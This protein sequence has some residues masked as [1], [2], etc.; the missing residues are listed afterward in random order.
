MAKN[1]NLFVHPVRLALYGPAGSGKDYVTKKIIEHFRFLQ[2]DEPKMMVDMKRFA[3][4]DKLK[5]IANIMIGM[6][7]DDTLALTIYSEEFK[8]KTFIDL[9]TLEVFHIDP[10]EEPHAYRSK[11][12]KGRVH[13]VFDGK[14]FIEDTNHYVF[15][16]AEDLVHL[17]AKGQLTED[18]KIIPNISSFWKYETIEYPEG[19][20]KDNFKYRRFISYREF[21]VWVGTYCFQNLLG[22]N[23]L[24]NMMFNSHDYQWYATNAW[25]GVIVTDMRFPHEY[26]ACKNRGFKIIKI[27]PEEKEV[28]I[29]NIAESYY[30]QFESDFDF[31]NS[32]DEGHFNQE[33]KR[34]REFVRDN[35]A[36]PFDESKHLEKIE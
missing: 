11:D 34:L 16:T 25:H 27:V 26:Q 15:Y 35:F 32:R 10:P 12:S 22:K 2:D 1:N 18:F 29:N 5:E 14:I 21:I 19:C 30:S 28:D 6:N 3:F 23:S 36:E 24:V 13:K 20:N 4:A 7:N 33:M 8:N 31:F 9:D 17:C